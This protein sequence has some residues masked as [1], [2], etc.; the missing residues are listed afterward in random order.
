VSIRTC[1]PAVHPCD[2]SSAACC[3]CYSGAHL[4]R[5]FTSWR[6]RRTLKRYLTSQAGCASI[7]R[8]MELG[9]DEAPATGVWLQERRELVVRYRHT[10]TLQRIHKLP[11]ARKCEL[12][13]HARAPS[14]AS[15]TRPPDRMPSPRH[16][17]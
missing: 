7:L 8:H 4:P 6:R 3:A 1:G 2:L 9:T 17:L 5:T 12:E 13:E 11:G 16:G 14:G 15:S 10:L